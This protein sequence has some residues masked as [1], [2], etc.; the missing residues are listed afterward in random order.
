M[1]FNSVV[2]KKL[3]K[4]AWKSGGLTVGHD[5]EAEEYF[6]QGGYW[7]IRIKDDAIPNKDK[8]ALIELIGDFPAEGEVFKA[9]AGVGNQYEIPF[10][11]VWN[12]GRQWEL[13]KTEYHKTNIMM[14]QK[15]SLCRVL[16]EE[17]SGKCVLLNE[18]F[19][20]LIDITAMD[21]QKESEP[22]GPIAIGKEGTMLYWKN[23]LCMLAAC[24][25]QP[26][27]KNYELKLMDAIATIDIGVL[28]GI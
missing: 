2:F 26:N 12:I 16:Q 19:I 25:R 7:I 9:I 3:I 28:E 8:A 5:G 20:D 14:Y 1:F 23:Q 11:D 18:I 21:K 17:E 24:I 22:I 15:E 6:L 4:Q 13:A 27:E 10:N